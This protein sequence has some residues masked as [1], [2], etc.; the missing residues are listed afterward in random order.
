M[1]LIDVEVLPCENVRREGRKSPLD[2]EYQFLVV[3]PFCGI[4]YYSDSVFC[5]LICI[6]QKL[7]LR[8]RFKYDGLFRKCR[9]RW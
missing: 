9:H 2:T 8:Q 5:I 4:K 6:S 7:T 3:K 1:V